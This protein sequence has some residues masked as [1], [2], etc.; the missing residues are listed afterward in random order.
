M[1]GLIFL[2]SSP[3]PTQSNCRLGSLLITTSAVMWSNR[4]DRTSQGVDV[5]AVLFRSS[6]RQMEKVSKT[7]AK[8][9][10]GKGAQGEGACPERLSRVSTA[11]GKGKGLLPVL[12]V[13]QPVAAPPA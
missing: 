2:R 7:K 13:S 4:P 1:R 5:H 11:K 9:S 8:K 6:P 12:V 3:L 10:Q